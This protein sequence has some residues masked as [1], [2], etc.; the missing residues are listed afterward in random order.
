MGKDKETK[1]SETTTASVPIKKNK[2]KSRRRKNLNFH[3][4]IYKTLKS[5]HPGIGLYSDSIEILNSMTE[6]LFT[7]LSN[8]AAKLC[9]ARGI[10][11][12]SP[13]HIQYAASLLLPQDISKNANNSARKAVQTYNSSL[14][15]D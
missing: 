7:R 4:Y 12:M 2:R 13:R 11:T 6:D 3:T 14:E 1:S 5:V 9:R 8:E 15:D 10:Q